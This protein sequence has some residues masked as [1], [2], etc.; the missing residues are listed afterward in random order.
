M[1]VVRLVTENSSKLLSQTL[2][3]WEIGGT[4][5]GGVDVVGHR[6]R[7]LRHRA[8]DIFWLGLRNDRFRNGDRQERR[9]VR[10]SIPSV[11][12]G[13]VLTGLDTLFTMIFQRVWKVSET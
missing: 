2:K 4:G 1:L 7:I 6:C 3:E 9:S 12:S 10:I 11:F 8:I 13:Y 5:E